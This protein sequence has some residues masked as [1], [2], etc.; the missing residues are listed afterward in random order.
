[1]ILYGNPSG[2]RHSGRRCGAG[3]PGR[4]I[5]KPRQGRRRPRERKSGRAATQKQGHSSAHTFKEQIMTEKQFANITVEMW[6]LNQ[7]AA[8]LKSNARLLRKHPQASAYKLLVFKTKKE[9][10]EFCRL[11]SRWLS[12]SNKLKMSWSSRTDDSILLAHEEELNA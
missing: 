5:E 7:R 9:H 3:P 12:L 10:Y 2:R 1:V 8:A 11:R 6:R 4:A